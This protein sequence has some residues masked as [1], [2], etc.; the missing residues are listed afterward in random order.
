MF[1]SLPQNTCWIK[2][3]GQRNEGIAATIVI[4]VANDVHDAEGLVRVGLVL[5]DLHIQDNWGRRIQV[6]GVLLHPESGGGRLVQLDI[7]GSPQIQFAAL[8][9]LAE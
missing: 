7:G 5:G 1:F 8:I 6:G 3:L 9:F 4:F 2:I